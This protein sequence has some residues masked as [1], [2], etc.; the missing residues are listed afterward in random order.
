VIPNEPKLSLAQKVLYS[1]PT[2]AGAAI[3]IPLLIHLPKFYSDVV[4]VPIGYIALAI[5]V[6]RALDAMVDPAI[7]W[8]SDRTNTRLGRR[9]P[10]MLLGAPFAA[11]ALYFM[12]APPESLEPARA[13][14]W[15]GVT[16]AFYFFFHAIYEIP[17]LGM[18]AELTLDYHERSSLYGWRTAFLISG[19]FVA[20]VLPVVL[21]SR[22]PRGAM[23]AT[24]TLLA[25]LLVVLYLLLVVGVRERRRVTI[26]STNALVPGVR[27]AVRNRPFM[28][29]FLTLVIASL[30]AAIPALL[31]PYYVDYVIDPADTQKTVAYFLVLYFGTSFFCVPLWVAAAR[32]FGKLHAWLAS[33]VIGISAGIGLFFAGKGDVQ[34]VAL[35]HV[36]AGIAFGAG[37][38]LFPAMQAD[39]IDYDELHTGQRREAQFTAFWAL[40][41]KLVAI[42]GAALPIAVL[43][44]LGYVP[45]QDQSP[46]VLMG[47][48]VIYALV[49]AACA[50]VAF[51]LGRRYNVTQQVHEKIRAGIAAHARGESAVDPLTGRVI[52][53][54]ASRVVD[55]DTA[56]FLDHFSPGELRHVL[57]RGAAGLRARVVA[58]AAACVALSV[59]AVAI[60]IS[61][62]P[63]VHEEPG[64]LPVLSV[65]SAGFA[66]TGAAFHALRLRPAARLAAQPIAPELLRAHLE[67]NQRAAPPAGAAAEALQRAS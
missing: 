1:A 23:A 47:I 44:Q 43:A 28:I 58:K 33:F 39:V 51:F 19:T 29:L 27:V 62:L 59:A 65:V 6:A 42:P 11:V 26:H 30:P 17:Y 15:F 4:L 53:P 8:L 40:V 48:R 24:G 9:R 50:T 67:Q 57:E 21:A 31:L 52:P 5:A 45:N 18:G 22:G 61:T 16:F 54:P 46:T 7:G 25:V 36:W 34:W 13:G 37:F 55:P 38:L 32:R 3:A 20:S 41:P 2:F 35:L 64:L 12:L 63:A 60:C 14:V 66:L 56:W 49:P 10:Y